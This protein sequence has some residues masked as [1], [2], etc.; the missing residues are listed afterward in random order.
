MKKKPWKR[1]EDRKIN[2]K[3]IKDYIYILNIFKYINNN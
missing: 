2:N 1:Y 3:E